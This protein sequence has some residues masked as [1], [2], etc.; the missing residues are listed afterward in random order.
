MP[1]FASQTRVFVMFKVLIPAAAA[2]GLVAFAAQSQSADPRTDAN[3]LPMAWHLSHEGA[4]AKLAYGVANSDQLAVMMTCAPGDRVAV[5][6]G[7]V[8]P[9]GARLIQT[10]MSGSAEI[11]PMTGDLARE[12]RI[13]L[14]DPALRS[15]VE[16]GALPVRGD[17]GRGSLPADRSERR[18]IADFLSYCGSNRA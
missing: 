2:L 5:V 11:D 16:D 3:A 10:S 1:A 6:Y 18:M 15:L 7:A 8:Q 12:S 9:V 13:G 17:A 14:T 4:M